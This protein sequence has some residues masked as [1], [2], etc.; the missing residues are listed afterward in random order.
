VL[1]RLAFGPAGEQGNLFAVETREIDGRT[2]AFTADMGGRLIVFDVSGDVL[3]PAP[4]DP[5]QP[6][7]SLAPVSVWTCP[8]NAFDG[9]RDNVINV[10]VDPPHVYLATGR[11][12][13]T[14][15]EFSTADR[16]L[17]EIPDSP[18]LTPGLALGS[19]VRHAGA[20]TT[21]VVGDSRA[22]LR[23][24]DRAAQ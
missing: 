4:D 6:T 21:L 11:R 18:V 12:G 2:Y 8:V 10:A 3:F 15:L 7:S 13:L 19:I 1:L 23:L 24:L 9:F 16:S 20:S 17:H 5:T 14:V 22:G